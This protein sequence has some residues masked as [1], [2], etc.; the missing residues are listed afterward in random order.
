LCKGSRKEA[1]R[2]V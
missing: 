2:E 1:S